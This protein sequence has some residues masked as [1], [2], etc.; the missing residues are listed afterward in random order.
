MDG[1]N[2]WKWTIA[3]AAGV[4]VLLIRRSFNQQKLLCKSK[5]RMDGKTVVITGANCGI[6]EA[7]AQELAKRGARLILACRD[8]SKGEKAASKIR[9]R[10]PDADVVVKHLDL[11]S[12]Q[13]VNQLA[14]GLIDEEAK[15]D[16]L[17]NNAGIY[18]CPYMNTEDGFEM[19]MG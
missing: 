9:K 2:W 16:V 7:T 3:G 8:T 19:Q 15:I 4:T 18:Q 12:L 14:T 6:G 10:V 1:S 13:S 5:A 11:A 17:I